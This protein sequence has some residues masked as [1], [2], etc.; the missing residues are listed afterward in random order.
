MRHVMPGILSVTERCQSR[1]KTSHSRSAWR[2]GV[3]LLSRSD[4]RRWPDC[5]RSR[6]GGVAGSYKVY[7]EDAHVFAA[8]AY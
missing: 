4:S 7:D 3:A 6:S 2:E 8:L 5:V 1:W